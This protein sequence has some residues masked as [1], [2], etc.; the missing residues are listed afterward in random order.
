MLGGTVHHLT[1]FHED[2]WIEDLQNRKPDLVILN[3]GTNES[4][5]GYLPY[6]EYLHNYSVV[7]RAHP[8]GASRRVDPDHG[9]HGSRRAQR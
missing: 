9:A 4:N 5:Y 2:T 8:D 6:A 3:F 7:I 1:L